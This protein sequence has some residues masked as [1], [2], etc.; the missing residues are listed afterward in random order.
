MISTK[1]AINSC[2]L[3]THIVSRCRIA[4]ATLSD[5]GFGPTT[6]A[7][8]SKSNCLNGLYLTF[9]FRHKTPVSYRVENNVWIGLWL[10]ARIWNSSCLKLLI[11]NFTCCGADQRCSSVSSGGLQYRVPTLQLLH[12]CL[13]GEEGHHD[14]ID[15]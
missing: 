9:F 14:G 3:V 15:R 10:F 8:R 7:N 6:N 13:H 4:T 11:K 12:G 2:K 1:K 5:L